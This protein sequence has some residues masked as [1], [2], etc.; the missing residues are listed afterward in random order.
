MVNPDSTRN[1]LAVVD[2]PCLC[3]EGGLHL[4]NSAMVSGGRLDGKVALT[5]GGGGGGFN[6]TAGEAH[7]RLLQNVPLGKT[8]GRLSL[9][10]ESPSHVVHL[11][12]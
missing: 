2:R 8:E 1:E 4:L 9:L 12:A 6:A 7:H 11:V 10:A 3:S 5:E